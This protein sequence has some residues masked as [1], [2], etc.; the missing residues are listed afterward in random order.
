MRAL[1]RLGHEVRLVY[2]R[3][4][5]PGDLEHYLSEDLRGNAPLLL[6][7]DEGRRALM[8]VIFYNVA[9]EFRP[10]L[11]LLAG[12]Y[13]TWSSDALADVED[14]LGV[15]VILWSGDNPYVP[16][17]PDIFERAPYYRSVLFANFRFADRA[18]DRFAH[19]DYLPFG[20][21]PTRDLPPEATD[22]LDPYGCDLSYL[23]TYKEERAQLLDTLA[24][25][26]FEMKVWGVGYPDDFARR[27]AN[28][29]A[30]LQPEHVQGRE[31]IKVYGG[32]KIVLNLHHTGFANMK[33]YE[34]AACG[35]FQISNKRLEA[36][37]TRHRLGLC[38]EMVTYERPEELVE[39]IDYYL[40]HPQQRASRARRLRE[41]VLAEHTWDQR[42]ASILALVAPS[43][44]PRTTLEPT[45]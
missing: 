19:T 7:S 14:N 29:A 30:V 12:I 5:Q 13:Y 42:M 8:E 34:A 11:I 31:K 9:A 39:L 21:D 1:E 33:L 41:L 4:P 43:P 2:H 16:N 24:S 40:S 17:A 20:C 10:E 36:E 23:G 15:P 35:A 32:S 38:D 26:D 25:R 3:T 45:S 37:S 27:F 18:A 44:A 6:E 22:E 28:L